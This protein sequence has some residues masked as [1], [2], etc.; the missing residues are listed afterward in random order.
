MGAGHSRNL[1]EA[2]AANELDRARHFMKEDKKAVTQAD[3]V[4]RASLLLRCPTCRRPADSLSLA[5]VPHCLSGRT[6]CPHFDLQ[7][8]SLC[9]RATSACHHILSRDWHA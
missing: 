6:C 4:C 5:C 3:K 7:A 9:V 1:Y 8:G 2:A